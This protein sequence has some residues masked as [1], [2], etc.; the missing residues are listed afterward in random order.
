MTIGEVVTEPESWWWEWVKMRLESGWEW[1]RRVRGRG[2]AMG[3]RLLI[4]VLWNESGWV[5]WR[6]M[7]GG[8]GEWRE[9]RVR[10]IRFIYIYIY[11]FFGNFAFKW[12][13]LGL[14]CVLLKLAPDLNSLPTWTRFEFYFKN[15]NP[16]LLFCGLGK[17]RP[18]GLGWI[19]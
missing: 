12:V 2:D 16:T 19:R 5:E 7:G 9:T 1:V 6:E 8:W 18:L 15:P 10:E 17:T 11:R 4:V 14:G 13:G 3:G